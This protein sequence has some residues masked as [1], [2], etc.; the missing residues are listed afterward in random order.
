MTTN[1]SLNLP[2]M[3][4]KLTVVESTDASLVGR[5]GCVVDETL[6]T[7]SIIDQD[8]ERR[9]VIGKSS[10]KFQLDDETQVIDGRIVQV[11][12]E[13]RINRRFA[14]SGEGE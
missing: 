9:V 14:I 1:I 13:D 12:P 2:W 8:N 3:G 7:I 6:R 4:R 5:S 11:R 10:I